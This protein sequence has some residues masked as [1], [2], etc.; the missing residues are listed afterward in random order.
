MQKINVNDLNGIESTPLKVITRV[1]QEADPLKFSDLCSN[2]LSDFIGREESIVNY[3]IHSHIIQ[4]VNGAVLV[5]T[6][7]L[8][9]LATEQEEKEYKEEIKRANLFIKP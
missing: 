2:M 8:Q 9:H 1:I 4:S 6:A 7:I 5:F 3:S